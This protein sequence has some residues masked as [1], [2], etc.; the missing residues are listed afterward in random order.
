MK[1]IGKIIRAMTTLIS[2]VVMIAVCTVLYARFIEP[3][4]LITNRFSVS[5]PNVKE[6]FTVVFFSDTHFSGIY[7]EQNIEK[8]VERINRQNADIVVFGGDFFDNYQKEKDILDLDYM[9]EQL[10]S[11]EAGYGKYCIWGNHDKGGGSAKIYAEMMEKGGFTLL[12]NESIL[13]EEL[14]LEIRGLDDYLL[15]NPDTSTDMMQASRVNIIL[16]HAPD[17]IDDMDGTNTDIMLSGHSHGGQVFVPEITKKILPDGAKKYVKGL[18][19]FKNSRDSKLIVSKGIG[20]TQIPY[21]FLNIPEIMVL[22]MR[23]PS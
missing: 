3:N 21:R 9:E 7:P 14:N 19:L 16:S 4:M 12:K 1:A 17:I 20:T 10:S 8:I 22:E 5:S 6:A 2:T 15:G 18:Y 13:I 11:I 23:P